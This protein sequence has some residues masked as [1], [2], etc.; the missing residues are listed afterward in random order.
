[1]K[2]L[3]WEDIAQ[4]VGFYLADE[5]REDAHR[6]LADGADGVDF[7]LAVEQLHGAGTV[8][9][10]AVSAGYEAEARWALQQR[11]VREGWC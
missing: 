6:F 7:L 1:M 5:V 3:N 10:A 2:D 11:R 4:D 9:D 8:L